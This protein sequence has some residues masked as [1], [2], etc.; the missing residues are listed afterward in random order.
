MNEKSNGEIQ[1]DLG[2]DLKG[3]FKVNYAV[4][5]GTHIFK[6]DIQ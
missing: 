6:T 5:K 4:L 2:L 3:Y 1:F